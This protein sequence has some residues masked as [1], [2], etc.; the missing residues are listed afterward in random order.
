MIAT[1]IIRRNDIGLV[2]IVERQLMRV[3]LHID[4]HRRVF[5]ERDEELSVVARVEL[6]LDEGRWEL[7]FARTVARHHVKHTYRV[8]GG[9]AQQQL[10]VTAP[11]QRAHW[12]YVRCENFC[13]ASCQ[14]VP[15]EDAAVV[16][17]YR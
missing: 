13:D 3:G 9:S 4:E 7:I 10:A 17:A 1:P 16:A 8:V 6:D 12:V 14:E 11:A 5:E 2:G 15:D